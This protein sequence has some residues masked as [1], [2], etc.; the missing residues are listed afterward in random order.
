MDLNKAAKELLESSNNVDRVSIWDYSNVLGSTCPLCEATPDSHEH[1]FFICPFA[2][3]VW[4]RMKVKAG[5]GR[6]SHNIYDIV[7]HFGGI[8]RRKTTHVVIAKLVVAASAYFIWQERNWRLFKKSKRS[9]DQRERNNVE[10]LVQPHTNSARMNP[11]FARFPQEVMDQYDVQGMHSSRDSE[12]DGLGNTSWGLYKNFS[13]EE[14]VS[15]RQYDNVQIHVLQQ[16]NSARMPLSVAQFP[17]ADS[18]QNYVHDNHS[19]PTKSSDSEVTRSPGELKKGKRKWLWSFIGMSTVI[20][21]LILAYSYAAHD[22]E[23]QSSGTSSDTKPQ[24]GKVNDCF[25]GTLRR[26]EDFAGLSFRFIIGKTCDKSELAKLRKDVK[27]YDDFLLLDIEEGLFLFYLLASTNDYFTHLI[28]SYLVE[29]NLRTLEVNSV[30]SEPESSEFLKRHRTEHERSLSCF[31]YR[32]E[33]LSKILSEESVKTF[34][35]LNVGSRNGRGFALLFMLRYVWPGSFFGFFLLQVRSILLSFTLFTFPFS[36]PY[37]SS[38]SQPAGESI[39]LK[40]DTHVYT[41]VLTP[42]EVN[43]L[44]TE[45]A[46]PTDLHPCVPPSDLTINRLPQDKIGI[47]DQYL[48]LSGHWKDRFFPIVRLAVP[49]AMPWRHQ[50]S[51]VA[52]PPPTSVRAADICRLCEHV[53]DLCLVHPAML[54]VI[55]LTTIWKYVGHH[56]VFKDGEGNVA[57]IM[58]QFLKF[59]MAGG[60]RVGKGSALTAN[61]AI[62]QHTTPPLPS[63]AQIPA[64]SDHQKVVEVK[65]ERVLAAKRKTQAAKDKAAGKRAAAERAS[66][67][68]KKKKGATLSFALDDTEE[69][70]SIHTG[71]LASESARHEEDETD[72]HFDSVDDGTEANSPPAVHHSESQHSIHS[73][74]DTPVH[75]GRPQ[76][77]ERDG[78]GHQHASGHVVSS[79]SG[80]ST[81]LAFPQRNPGGDTIGSSLRGDA[82]QLSLFV[83]AWNL[84]TNSILNDAESCCDMMALQR[85]WFEL[86]RGALAQIDLLQ[87]YEALND[88]YSDLYDTHRPCETVS[89]RLTDT[90]NQLVDVVRGR[91]KLADDHKSLQKE[92]LGCA[93]KEAALVEKLVVAKKEKDDLLDKNREQEEC[94]KQLEEDLASK[95]SSL[96]SAQSSISSL[97]SD[98]ERLTVDLSQAEIVRHNYV[99]QLLPTGVKAVLS[100]EEAEAFLATAVDYDPA[101]KDTFISEF[102]SLFVKNYPYVEKLTESFRLSLGDLQNMWPEG[103]GATLSVKTRFVEPVNTSL[104]H[105][106]LDSSGASFALGKV[107]HLAIGSW[108]HPEHLLLRVKYVTWPLALGLIR[109]IFCFGQNTSLGH[110]LLDSSEA[111]F[112]SGSSTSLGHWLLDS[113]GASSISGKI[114]H[115]AIGSWT[116]PEHLFA[117]GQVCHL[118]IGSWTHPEHLLLRVKYATWPLALGLI[119]SVLR[120]GSGYVTW[121]LALGLIRSG[122]SHFGPNLPWSSTLLASFL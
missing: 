55:G 67:P 29:V 17:Q 54:Y 27:E 33:V 11:N 20:R 7:D 26:L 60:V 53:V 31:G 119:R 57:T 38:G 75:S 68:S 91:N 21:A 110:W 8:A 28:N 44:V 30:P 83:P 40:F 89:D 1:L 23:H 9:I 86:G 113:S 95:T 97:R 120:F 116:H 115:L 80:G 15:Q 35:L 47:Y 105:W 51:S 32:Q 81:R 76:H 39:I 14:Y 73:T 99:P 103:T 3:S 112:C 36:L 109:S 121:P 62:P 6:V 58:A 82:A 4:S 56:P 87:R 71:D 79:F 22:S 59:P 78:R 5:L 2:N 93:G 63:G 98:L 42:D 122:P 88:D 50:D 90:Q 74:E 43:N 52:D 108:T 96:T 107:C 84:T 114:R 65:N 25:D 46:I 104:G 100:E 117:P 101:C 70:D 41:S 85:A 18:D 34:P 24:V 106:L 118:G 13:L 61:E 10:T 45:Y 64:K 16:T 37:M 102:D 92:H 19:E 77:D 72:H 49:N 94:I 48:E 66:R 69:D 111:S 12:N